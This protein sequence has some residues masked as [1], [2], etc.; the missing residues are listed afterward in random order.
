M[1]VLDNEALCNRLLDRQLLAETWL[2][3]DCVIYYIILDTLYK[4]I[5]N[6]TPLV[7][8]LNIYIL[9]SIKYSNYLSKTSTLKYWLKKKRNLTIWARQIW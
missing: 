2:N 6:A 9:I 5:K 7:G 3:S 4:E 8:K 1:H